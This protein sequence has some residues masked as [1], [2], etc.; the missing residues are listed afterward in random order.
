MAW[1]MK[2]M[3][4]DDH[5]LM[6]ENL[7]LFCSDW[8]GVLPGDHQPHPGD[9]EAG[10]VQAHG[11]EQDHPAHRWDSMLTIANISVSLQYLYFCSLFVSF[12]P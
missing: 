8:R 3:A 4:T 7:L 9:Q 2:N 1:G 5:F 11:R 6:T 10:S 12:F